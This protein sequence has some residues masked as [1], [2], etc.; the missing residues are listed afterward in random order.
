MDSET[1][2][3]RQPLAS[4]P[5]REPP[6]LAH[7]YVC[8]ATPNIVVG[9][10]SNRFW[11]SKTNL[12][13]KSIKVA[14]K[15]IL[16]KT[17]NL[18]PHKI[19]HTEVHNST[20]RDS[21]E[22]KRPTCPSAGCWHTRCCP[23]TQWN[24]TRQQKSP[25][26]WYTNQRGALSMPSRGEPTALLEGAPMMSFHLRGGCLCTDRKE[27]EKTL[28]WSMSHRALGD[29]SCVSACSDTIDLNSRSVRSTVWGF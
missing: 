3:A 25:D 29:D 18:S 15:Y 6:H 13:N 27:H 8:I 20:V 17:E 5:S 24:T 4:V 22:R 2:T 23:A 11:H 7:N 12:T 14:R 10:S 26:Y 1:Q 28:G 19:L 21:P 16:Q 9:V